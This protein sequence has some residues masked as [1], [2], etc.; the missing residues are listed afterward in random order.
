MYFVYIIKSTKTGRYYKG[1]TKNLPERLAYHNAGYVPSTQHD[2]P[3]ELIW[4]CQ[5]PN[6]SEAC[7][8]ERKLKNLSQKRLLQFIENKVS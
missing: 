7:I 6:K 8:L 3:W 1:I 5:K 2:K 4:F